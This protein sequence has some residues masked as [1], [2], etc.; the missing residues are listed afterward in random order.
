[1]P[2]V[3]SPKRAKITFSTMSL[4]ESLLHSYFYLPIC[5]SI[6]NADFCRSYLGAAGAIAKV[7][8]P[9][10]RYFERAA[11]AAAASCLALSLMTFVARM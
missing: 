8:I 7:R 11:A 1:M 4:G 3:P 6:C 2:S 10:L 9:L 5:L